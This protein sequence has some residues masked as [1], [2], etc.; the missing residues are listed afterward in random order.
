MAKKGIMTKIGVW[1]FILGVVIAILAGFIGPLATPTLVVIGVIIGLLNVTD[2]ET[3]AFL[4]AAVSIMIAA[5][6][7]GSAIEGSLNTLGAVGMYL[8]QLLVNINVLVFPATIVV[9]LKAV[10]SIARD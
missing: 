3:S 10:Y 2:K 5:Y 4:M 7:A 9:A 8:A 6:T 1:A